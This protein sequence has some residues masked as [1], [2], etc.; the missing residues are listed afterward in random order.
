MPIDGNVVPFPRQLRVVPLVEDA[1]QEP[2]VVS[3]IMV[4]HNGSIYRLADLMRALLDQKMGLLNSLA[5]R[6]GQEIWDAVVRQWPLLADDLT[7]LAIYWPAFLQET[8]P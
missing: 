4:E 8:H 3:P 1:V 7:S 6:S 5:P 2:L